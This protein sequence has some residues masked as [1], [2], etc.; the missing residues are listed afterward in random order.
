MQDV[1][2]IG[3]G[4]S[5]AMVLAGIVKN[6]SKPLSIAI[7]DPNPEPAL[8][9]AY[10]TR[11][12]FHLL[13][14]R[15]SK[16]GAFADDE[17]GFIDWLATDAANI[18]C[19]KNGLSVQWKDE[20][21]APRMLYGAYLQHIW[22][23]TLAM[24]AEK[25]I[26]VVFYK[27]EA[28][29]IIPQESHFTL[30]T[31]YEKIEAQHVVLAT[32]N[33]FAKEDGQTRYVYDVWNFD[34]TGFAK[35]E[36]GN[37]RPAIIVGMGLTAIDTVFSLRDGGFEKP[38]IMLSRRALLPAIHE[39]YAPYRGEIPKESSLLTLM[40]WV[41]ATAEQEMKNGGSWQAVVDSLRPHMLRLWA[42]LGTKDKK[43]FF[44]KLFTFWNI[45]RHRM[46]SEIGNPLLQ[47]VQEGDI[48]LKQGRLLSAR[49]QTNFITAQLSLETIDAAAIFHCVGPDYRGI[50]ETPL[51]ATLF[52]QNLLQKSASGFG[53]ITDKMGIA[54]QDVHKSIFALGNYCLGERL[55][56][57]AVPEL[58]VQAAE[59]GASLS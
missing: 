35:S 29:R 12:P 57:T 37:N 13:N 40:R 21:F 54:Y 24:A 26:R 49:E 10:A 22:M 7:I 38:V 34:F 56:T 53:L 3:C 41:R 9:I 52:E 33:R 23:H 46:A 43:L 1:A 14:V 36:A 30:L 2:I 51:L 4:F 47:A 39:A 15:A 31:P 44:R 45:H 18:F 19:R 6:T 58:R 59:V 48:I 25:K 17:R 27:E 42:H 16:M 11:K 50:T 28:E 8:G 5:G 32:G 20:D 55:E